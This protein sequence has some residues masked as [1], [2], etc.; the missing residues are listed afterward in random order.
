[1]QII[2]THIEE[3][4]ILE[5]KVFGDERGFFME[6][7]RDSW[8][9]ECIADVDF[10]QHNHS[11]SNKNILRGLHYQFKKPQGKLV[12]VISGSVLDV[13]V[14][15]RQKSKTFG[16]HITVELSAQN[17]KQLWVPPG[18]AHGFYVLSDNTEFVYQC[19][20]YYTPEDEFS[21]LWNDPTLSI[22]WK[23]TDNNKL[24]LSE[25]DKNGLLFKETPYYE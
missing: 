11:K 20:D 8:F 3:V 18:F 2:N 14:D 15:L 5:P 21:L 17:K 13:A 4:K 19:T 23:I 6:T 24:L 1:M 25:K 12:R 10:V 22:D 16:H 9:R 7:Y